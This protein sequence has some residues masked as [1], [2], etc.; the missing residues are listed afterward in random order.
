MFQAY[1][2]QQEHSQWLGLG[3]LARST[4]FCRVQRKFP[5]ERASRAWAKWTQGRT[6]NAGCSAR[7]PCG[8]MLMWY[9]NPGWHQCQ[10]RMNT[11]WSLLTTI[12]L[13]KNEMV[14]RIITLWFSTG[15]L[16][17]LWILWLKIL[18]YIWHYHNPF[19]GSLW[20]FLL[21]NPLHFSW[22]SLKSWQEN[23]Y[24]AVNHIK[25]GF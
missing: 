2:C 22:N 23:C 13:R 4:T 20:E 14:P 19:V 17:A 3:Q 8:S 5:G 1:F 9:K 25:M 18:R 6:G 16:Y 21:T 10:S 11:W 24:N 15:A 7:G 12:D